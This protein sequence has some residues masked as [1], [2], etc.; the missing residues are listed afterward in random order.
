MDNANTFYRWFNADKLKKLIRFIVVSR[1]G[2]K[3]NPKV[4]WYKKSP[5][6]YLDAKDSISNISSTKIRKWIKE[7]NYPKAFNSMHY[8]VYNYAVMKQNLY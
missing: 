6:I 1:Q 7:R 3:P 2:I 4:T 8:R 5:H